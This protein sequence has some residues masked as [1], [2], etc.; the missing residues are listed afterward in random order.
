[1]ALY[2]GTGLPGW[3]SQES[4]LWFGSRIPASSSSLHLL[5]PGDTHPS[6]A[7]AWERALSMRV[8]APGRPVCSQ[9][10]CGG[11]VGA[12]DGWFSRRSH[13]CDMWRLHLFTQNSGPTWAGEFT[14]SVYRLSSPAGPWPSWGS[15][16]ST[17]RVEGWC[18]SQQ[19]GAPCPL[20]DT[21]RLDGVLLGNHWS[22]HHPFMT[23]TPQ[24]HSPRVLFATDF[25]TRILAQVQCCIATV[26]R[27]EQR[28]VELS[29][30]PSPCPPQPFDLGRSALTVCG[31]DSWTSV[32]N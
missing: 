2:L 15:L 4:W 24:E 29:N 16:A 25:P 27:R 8:E 22:A 13:A 26:M 3:S 23:E 7:L 28:T 10:I 12:R 21:P 11:G 9:Q 14:V 1:M 20:S 6:S 18:G 17:S 5:L 31:Q 32:L 19:A 30:S